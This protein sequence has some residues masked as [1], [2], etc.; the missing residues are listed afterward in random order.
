MTNEQ[1]SSFSQFNDLPMEIR[2]EIL[3]TY[4]E[5]LEQA[6]FLMRGY[7]EYLKDKLCDLGITQDELVSY[8]KDNDVSVFGA[9]T[10]ENRVPHACIYLYAPNHYQRVEW[11]S[12]CYNRSM[13]P[14]LYMVLYKDMDPTGLFSLNNMS[15]ILFDDLVKLDYLTTYNVL[16]RRLGCDPSR[17]KQKLLQDFREKDQ[18]FQAKINSQPVIGYVELYFE[19]IINA[20]IFEDRSEIVE[21]Y[22]R[23]TVN[24]PSDPTFLDLKRKVDKLRHNVHDFL[25]NLPETRIFPLLKQYVNSTS[26][27]SLLISE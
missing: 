14:Q 22:L 7:A 20:F 11:Q 8:I 27:L 19:L 17:I 5:T 21:E 25:I 9:H 16:I 1:D 10:I 23:L 3:S 4:P 26:Y 6:P 13:K 2:G 15:N 18:H 24:N 12:I